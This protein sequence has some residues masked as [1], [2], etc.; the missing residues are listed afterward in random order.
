MDPAL[1]SSLPLVAWAIFAAATGL[2]IALGGILAYHWFRYAMNPAISSIS[3][4]IYIVV[5]LIFLSSL[6]AATLLIGTSV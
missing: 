2:A 4:V 3:L 6:L 1:I 5:T